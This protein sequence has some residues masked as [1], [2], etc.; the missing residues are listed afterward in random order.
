MNITN[1]QIT[2]NKNNYSI[3][4]SFIAPAEGVYHVELSSSIAV[5]D[6]C[7]LYADLDYDL[8]AAIRKGRNVS[9]LVKKSSSTRFTDFQKTISWKF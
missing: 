4:Y 9:E 3:I 1:E 6:L 5:T 7:Y 2:R 8:N